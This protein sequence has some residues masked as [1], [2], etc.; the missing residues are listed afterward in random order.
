VAFATLVIGTGVLGWT[1]RIKPGD[2]LFYLAG[3]L[4]AVVWGGGAVLSGALRLGRA[5]TRSGRRTALPIVQSLALGALLLG[6]FL[7]GAAL[8]ARVP[9]LRRPVDDLLDHAQLGSLALVM[10]ITAVNGIA[11]E[12]YFR[13]ALYA[14]VN[15]RW[16]VAVTTVA[17]VVVTIFSGVP[18]LVLA[19]LVL[20]LITGLQRRVTGGILGPIVTHLVWSLGMLLLL[21][22]VLAALD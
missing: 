12:L 9:V 15:P 11:E 18:L 4:L 3:G 16:A 7:G 21:P 22:A 8:I 13:G 19:A 10:A 17:Y 5:H 6:I 2:P 1:L 20:G 14:A